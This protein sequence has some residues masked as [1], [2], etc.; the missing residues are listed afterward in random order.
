MKQALTIAL[1][2][3]SLYSR[4]QPAAPASIQA[5]LNVGGGSAAISTSF[6]VDWSIGESTIID[7]YQGENS[8]PSSVIG[9]TWYVTSGI[10]QPYDKNYLLFNPLLTNWSKDEIRVYPVPATD[11]VYIDFRTPISGKI[12]IQL[13]NTN[14]N[15]LET[16]E[17]K[18]V[19]ES[20]TESWNLGNKTSG[21]Y[22]FKIL[23]YGG[24][25]K[26]SKQGLFKIEKIK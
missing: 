3:L 19:S 21:V 18:G 6:I 17:L 4:S 15:V 25:R 10:L 1:L 12:S 20:S 14:G 26:I 24:Q 5:T 9:S 23:S 13:L 16:R 8:L 2:F 11:R 22:Y 7:T